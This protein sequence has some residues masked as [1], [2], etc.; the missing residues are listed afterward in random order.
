MFSNGLQ[1]F[2]AA[3]GRVPRG[4]QQ[5]LHRRPSHGRLLVLEV[6]GQAGQCLRIA[7][8]TEGQ[9]QHTDLPRLARTLQP[10]EQQLSGLLAVELASEIGGEQHD[11]VQIAAQQRQQH[12]ARAGCR[13]PAQ[14]TRH[15]QLHQR[16]RFLPGQQPEQ[17][18]F[19]LTYL[20]GQPA[21]QQASGRLR[22]GRGVVT[23]ELDQQGQLLA[24]GAGNQ[25]A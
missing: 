4:R 5:G 15:L 12:L 1:A 3:L 21:G 22:P 19:Q 2:P 9:Q 24:R 13:T 25:R 6:A 11:I 7:Q 20:S 23:I 18:Q 16:L 17:F 10:F 8:Q 14:L